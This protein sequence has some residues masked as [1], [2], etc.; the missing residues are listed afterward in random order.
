MAHDQQPPHVALRG[1]LAVQADLGQQVVPGA[2][3]R[4]RLEFDHVDRPVVPLGLVQAVQPPFDALDGQRA[5]DVRAGQGQPAGQHPEG[6]GVGRE[7]GVDG[8]IGFHTDQGMRFAFIIGLPPDNRINVIA[9][10]PIR[11]TSL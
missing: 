5:E 10:P 3:R 8:G 2:G 7:K 6:L 1:L 11:H 4:L 9:Q